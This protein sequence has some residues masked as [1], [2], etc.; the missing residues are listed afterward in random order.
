[1]KTGK[2]VL[3]AAAVV[4]VGIGSYLLYWEKVQHRF[5]VVTEHQLY[6]SAEMPPDEL[7]ELARNHGI[8]TVVD[9]RLTEDSRE[10]IAAQA[11]ALAGT[12]VENIHLPAHHVPDEATVMRFLEIVGDPAKRPVLV[13]CQHGTGRSVLFSSLFR[14][15][16]ENWD[17]ETARRA[18]EPLHWRGN[19][20]P[21]APKGAY[22]LDYQPH[23]IRL[24]V[25]ATARAAK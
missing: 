18:V 8:R 13:H 15:E 14:I 6:Q 3:L 12:D 19:F 24:E 22:L 17:N 20:A 11:A 7:L 16:F 21:D 4:V 1:M 5:T 25:A 2:T 23:E 10:D 9:L